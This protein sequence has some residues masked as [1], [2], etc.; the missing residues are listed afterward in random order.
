MR[1]IKYALPIACLLLAPVAQAQQ[2]PSRDDNWAT[3][4]TVSLVVGA[5][6][7]A[8]MPR[9]FYSDPEATV[10]WKARWHVSV[11]APALTLTTLAVLNEYTLKDSFEGY[12]PGCN[13]DLQGGPGCRTYG[14]LS[15][16]TYGN[17]AAL[18]QGTAIFLVDTLKWSQGKVNAGA[19]VGHLAIPLVTSVLT[20][21]S[22]SAG[23]WETGTQIF[24]GAGAGL[25]S[26]ALT[27]T[28][29]ALMQRPECGY[30]GSMI[31]W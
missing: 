21:I 23:D 19:A 30:T 9:I 18:G 29:Y 22:R 3:V 2:A 13:E 7:E 28:V 15:T 10:G 6:T 26:G 20:A 12:R 25:L 5:G 14:M 1:C 31:C 8:L 24:A 11:L 16:H 4:S 17:F 27:G